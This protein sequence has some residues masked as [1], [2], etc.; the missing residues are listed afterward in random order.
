MSGRRLSASLLGACV[1][2]AIGAVSVQALPSARVSAA[3][4]SVRAMVVGSGGA[5]LA[6]ARTVT[7][8]ATSVQV[9]RKH[10]TVAAGT[11]LAALAAVRRAGGPGFALRDY[12]RCGA[13]A[14]SSG[15]LFVDSLG[16]ESNS[17][18]NGWEYKVD[19]ISGSTGAADTSGPQGTGRRLS[20]GERVLWFWCEAASGGCQRTLEAFPASNSV[21]A[22]R[23]LTV[24]VYGY[25]NEGHGVPVAGAIVTLGEDFASTAANGRATLIAPTTHGSYQVSATRRGLVPSFPETIVVR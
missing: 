20:S 16:G 6:Q 24:T 7:A 17:G 15:E 13:V 18:Q 12:G 4:P 14:A 25:D 23:S 5:I 9:A 3:G 22:G 21:S 8:A 19:D 1:L 10:C 11:P 2:T